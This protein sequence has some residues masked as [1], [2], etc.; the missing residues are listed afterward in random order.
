MKIII[1]SI[2]FPS[3]RTRIGRKQLHGWGMISARWCPVLWWKFWSHRFA[4]DVECIPTYF[5]NSSS[6][7]LEIAS[8]F[9]HSQL[10]RP[11]ASCMTRLFLQLEVQRRWVHGLNSLLWRKVSWYLRKLRNKLKRQWLIE[12][13]WVKI[14]GKVL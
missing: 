7:D 9:S 8:Q 5:C 10:D 13:R 14:Q 1:F 4:I 2:P 12:E 6:P 3:W 11:K